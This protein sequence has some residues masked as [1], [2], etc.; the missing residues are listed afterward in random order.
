[1]TRELAVVLREYSRAVPCRP[2]PVERRSLCRRS[3]VVGR[4]WQ[5]STRGADSQGI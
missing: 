1:M 5:Y 2:A 3:M 4:I